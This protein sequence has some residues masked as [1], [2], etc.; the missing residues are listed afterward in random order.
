M[1]EECSIKQPVKGLVECDRN[2]DRSQMDDIQVHQKSLEATYADLHAQAHTNAELD[3]EGVVS[4]IANMGL[5]IFLDALGKSGTT[6]NPQDTLRVSRAAHGL[7]QQARTQRV[8][9]MC[10]NH[11]AQRDLRL[12]A[13]E[14]SMSK[15]SSMHLELTASV[16]RGVLVRCTLRIGF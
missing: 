12:Q 4:Y 9:L 16:A 10:S 7:A 14:G 1:N 15:L 11:G 13:G 5:W 8:V 6:P 3:R 2:D